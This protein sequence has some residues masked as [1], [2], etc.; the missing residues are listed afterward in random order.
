ME[1]TINDE[2]QSLITG[3]LTG[4]LNEIEIK[5][6]KEWLEEDPA[7]LHAF[8]EIRSAWILAGKPIGEAA[9]NADSSWNKNLKPL[10][11]KDNHN[12]R[13][14]IRSFKWDSF[15][16]Y[17]ASLALC[18]VLGALATLYWSNSKNAGANLELATTEI[19]APLGSIS[20]ITLPDGSKVWLNAGSKL[21][22]QKKFGINDRELELEGEA[23]FDVT[24]NPNKPFIVKTSDMSVRAFGT[25]FNVKAYPEESTVFATLE[26]GKVDVLFHNNEKQSTVSLKPNEELVF[27]KPNKDKNHTN[28]KQKGESDSQ[29]PADLQMAVNAEDIKVINVKTEHSTSWKDD[30][31]VV[32]DK[33]LVALLPDLERRFNLKI[34]IVSEELN[35]YRITTTI[36]NETAE[37]I[38]TALSH[39]IPVNYSIEKNQ[40]Q[41]SLNKKNQ[42][43]FKKVLKEK[44]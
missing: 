20:K 12:T 30:K 23:F 17:A 29:Q 9:F 4:S 19:Y 44:V 14:N 33:P 36:A 41:L 28:E 21:V 31:W 25:R 7:H 1:K 11:S 42:D 27:H 26:E 40:V 22:Y 6:L 3:F 35:D 5:Q 39:A 18:F 34:S 16:K 13:H 15:L 38:L 8:N 32:D 10:I 37:Q 2:I 43:K 24:T